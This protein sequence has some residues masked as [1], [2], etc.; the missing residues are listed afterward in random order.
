MVKIPKNGQFHNANNSKIRQISEAFDIR[1][2][3]AIDFIQETHL[4]LKTGKYL[5]EAIKFL[6]CG[7]IS[8]QT[9]IG[10]TTCELHSDRD[11]IV[12]V[13]TKRLAHQKSGKDHLYVASE[14]PDVRPATKDSDI[15]A[16]LLSNIKYKKIIVVADSLH[17]VI[18]AIG[19]TDYGKY[20][21]LIDEIDTFQSEIDY[22]KPIEDCIDYF[23]RFDQGA[24]ASATLREF[25]DPRFEKKGKY[26]LT[27]KGAGKIDLDV[28]EAKDL[29][30]AVKEK[31]LAF[32]QNEKILIALND[33]GVALD[34]CLILE[35]LDC[36]ILCSDQNDKVP[37]LQKRGLFG[38]LKGNR[39]PA[40]VNFITSAYYTGVDIED[41]CHVLIVA[42]HSKMYSLPSTEKIKQILGRPRNEF[43]SATLICKLGKVTPNDSYSLS[44]QD[45]ESLQT[46]IGQIGKNKN[47]EVYK[48]GFQDFM[49][50][51]PF[52][53]NIE[54][55]LGISFLQIDHH[56]IQKE[57]VKMYR[58]GGSLIS[59]FKKADFNPNHSQS[60]TR[61]SP[62]DKKIL[63][64]FHKNNVFEL[65]D[66]KTR[67]I[68]NKQRGTSHKIKI[69]YRNALELAYN[70]IFH[71]THN[72]KWTCKLIK[73]HITN[74]KKATL[75]MIL[76]RLR[77]ND[78]NNSERDTVFSQF[79]KGEKYTSTEIY[80]R[81]NTPKV[82]KV[83]LKIG[84]KLSQR[85]PVKALKIF[86]EVEKRGKKTNTGGKQQNAYRI[87]SRYSFGSLKPPVAYGF[88]DHCLLA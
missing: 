3:K 50:N 55:K 61:L 11:S 9:N 27:R 32:N 54:H 5:K 75:E 10:L 12:V 76:T 14:I 8:K 79:E 6:P 23:F 63:S 40:K 83:L 45:A 74:S 68:E 4:S 70:E 77:F 81:L 24:V 44:L 2:R 21:I 71:M 15:K 72:Q 52:R 43:H 88:D 33:V 42:D 86:F 87:K 28:I 25:T 66:A 56:Q 7:I 64:D 78:L 20:F 73:N 62:R 31:I 1:D 49:L 60:L 13:P 85:E 51:G 67:F 65:R 84:L 26:H 18:E 35:N 48:R 36:K 53:K 29:K 16:Y 69:K 57:I 38:E 19:S 47:L 80:Q 41:R 46:T 59:V 34:L 58:N 39:L 30:Q 17:R 22:R 37:D 82:H